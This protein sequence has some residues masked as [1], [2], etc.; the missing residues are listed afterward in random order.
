MTRPHTHSSSDPLSPSCPFLAWLQAPFQHTIPRPS[1]GVCAL[2]VPAPAHASRTR[3][4]HIGRSASGPP[5]ESL[6]HSTEV[7]PICQWRVPITLAR[8][9]SDRDAVAQGVCNADAQS[10][11]CLPWLALELIQDGLFEP[12]PLPWRPAVGD[13]VMELAAHLAWYVAPPPRQLSFLVQLRMQCVQCATLP[14][15]YCLTSSRLVS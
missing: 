2:A 12:R 15:T 3:I 5:R 6:V 1:D 9:G 7:L 13:S 4:S 8:L 14:S 11:A 10:E